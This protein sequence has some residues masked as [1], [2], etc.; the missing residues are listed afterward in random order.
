M[1]GGAQVLIDVNFRTIE[2]PWDEH[3]PI[4][5]VPQPSEVNARF[6][7]C[8]LNLGVALPNPSNVIMPPTHSSTSNVR[9]TLSLTTSALIAL[10]SARDGGSIALEMNL[11]AH[12]FVVARYP[13]SAPGLE[14]RPT[15]ET[16]RFSVPQERWLAALKQVGFCDTLVTELRLPASGPQSTAEGRQRLMQAVSARETGSYAEVMRKCRIALDAL[17]TSGFGGRAPAEVAGFLQ[18]NAS[19]LSQAERYSALQVA[20]HLFLSA[21]HHDG[22][23]EEEFNREDAELAIAMTAALLRLAPRWGVQDTER[24]SQEPS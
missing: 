7:R 16:Y 19:K 2:W 17:K 9:F 12:P 21:A 8:Q 3:G 24:D 6:A 4:S 23:P 14:V 5:L 15:S 22:M 20:T 11:V 13:D 1:A 10:E 18:K